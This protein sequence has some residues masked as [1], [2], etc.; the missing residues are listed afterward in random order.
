MQTESSR[1]QVHLTFSSL[2]VD[3]Y[4][5]EDLYG[6]VDDA[7][8][9]TV[10]LRPILLSLP[11]PRTFRLTQDRLLP[12]HRPL[13]TR[14]LSLLRWLPPKRPRRPLPLLPLPPVRRFQSPPFLP[15]QQ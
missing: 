5:D 3:I 7:D 15:N 6:P 1:E 9:N 4:G 2:K 8:V 12:L 13:T 14:R 10:S 11:Q